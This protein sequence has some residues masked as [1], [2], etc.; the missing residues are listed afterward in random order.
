MRR[1]AEAGVDPAV[2]EQL[3]P[4]APETEAAAA[5]QDVIAHAAARAGR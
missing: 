5:R 1:I 2:I 4:L 3:G